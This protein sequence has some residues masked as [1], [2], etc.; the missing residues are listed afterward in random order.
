MYPLLWLLIYA[1]LCAACDVSN[2]HSVLTSR[3]EET[4]VREVTLLLTDSTTEAPE[5]PTR[6][7]SA[8]KPLCY[9]QFHSGPPYGPDM[10]MS[11]QTTMSRDLP[12]TS[13]ID[14]EQET[15]ITP[16]LTQQ[17]ASSA[18]FGSSSDETTTSPITAPGDK[19]TDPPPTD[20]TTDMDSGSS[21]SNPASA[22]NTS[23]LET[24]TTM[25]ANGNKPASDVTE[26]LVD[27]ASTS[28]IEWKGKASS[29]TT[30]STKQPPPTT[31]MR[32]TTSSSEEAVPSQNTEP[33]EGEVQ[34]W[35]IPFGGA[36]ELLSHWLQD[37]G[38]ADWQF[39][40]DAKSGW[41]CLEGKK[42]FEASLDRLRE[43]KRLHPKLEYSA[44]NKLASIKLEVIDHTSTRPRFVRLYPSH[45]K[46]A[47]GRSDDLIDWIRLDL[48]NIDVSRTQRALLTGLSSRPNI[49]ELNTWIRS[50][51]GSDCLLVVAS[52][53]AHISSS[54][55]LVFICTLATANG[56]SVDKIEKF[57]D[58]AAFGSEVVSVLV[59]QGDSHI[60]ASERRQDAAPLVALGSSRLPP[61]WPRIVSR[62]NRCLAEERQKRQLETVHE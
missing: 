39:H 6:G 16:R 22:E 55:V 26:T 7:S 38:V 56:L 5:R 40:N 47:L 32:S 61:R 9:C 42:D 27:A 36:R 59:E 18:T 43:M 28:E 31:L 12:S 29:V 62:W 13:P 45:A 49:H 1:L 33:E 51:L 44:V 17:T 35:P 48:P 53:I 54:R 3:L 15:Q 37:C 30:T 19:M 20:R 52:R 46:K 23:P 10:T 34:Q 11:S 2:G 8:A 60:A 58:G 25:A 14:G 24:R 57:L 41:V 50:R 21:A 4:T